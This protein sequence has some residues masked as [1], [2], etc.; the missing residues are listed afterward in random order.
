MIFTISQDRLFPSCFIYRKLEVLTSREK[1]ESCFFFSKV[2][3]KKVYITRHSFGWPWVNANLKLLY[4]DRS[5]TRNWLKVVFHCQS[6]E[7][8]SMKRVLVKREIKVNSRIHRTETWSVIWSLFKCVA[9]NDYHHLVP[10]RT[11]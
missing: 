1:M 5:R 4:K 10:I 3:T 11:G 9:K 8:R 7:F 2:S 6:S